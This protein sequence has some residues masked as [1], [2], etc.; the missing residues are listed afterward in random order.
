MSEEVKTSAPE[1]KKEHSYTYWV[2]P[3]NKG[4]ELP[5]EH[6]PK[7]VDPPPEVETAYQL[8]HIVTTPAHPSGTRSARGRNAAFP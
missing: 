8:H 1:I 7:K 3:N 5:E 6:R 4:K 2:D